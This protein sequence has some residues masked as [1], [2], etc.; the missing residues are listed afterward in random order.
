MTG[1]EDKIRQI[2]A[3]LDVQVAEVEANI[4]VLKA[5]LVQDV[6]PGDEDPSLTPEATL[7]A[8]VQTRGCPVLFALSLAYKGGIFE[9]AA[10]CSP[11]DLGPTTVDLPAREGAALIGERPASVRRWASRSAGTPASSPSP[12][13]FARQPALGA[14][15]RNAVTG[16]RI[17]VQPECQQLILQ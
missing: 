8:S 6:V 11:A 7:E 15:D 9:H 12:V 2:V 14:L 10:W 17:P 13:G 5:L 3:E 16:E 4:A 1:R